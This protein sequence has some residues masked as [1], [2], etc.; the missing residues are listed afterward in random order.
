MS[1]GLARGQEAV[2]ASVTPVL[3]FILILLFLE[4]CRRRM[5]GIRIKSKIRKMI[6]SK[7]RLR[8]GPAISQY[9]PPI[10]SVKI[11]VQE[12]HESAAVAPRQECHRADPEQL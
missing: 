10:S 11:L 6:K 12:A 1:L 5:F 8:A 9:T 2:L 4:A 7:R 3:L